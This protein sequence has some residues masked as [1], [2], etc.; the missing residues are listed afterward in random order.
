[1]SDDAVDN[2]SYENNTTNYCQ[3]WPDT[4]QPASS[5]ADKISGEKEYKSKFYHFADPFFNQTFA[6]LFLIF[7]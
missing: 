2:N 7:S 6:P 3:Y 1:M 4:I 5:S